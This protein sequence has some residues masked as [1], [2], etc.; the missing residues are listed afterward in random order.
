[1]G[2]PVEE[3]GDLRKK[4]KSRGDN[5]GFND[6]DSTGL[7]R[8]ASE[9]QARKVLSDVDPWTAW[10][11]KPHTIITTLVGAGLLVWASGALQ[12]EEHDLDP[13]TNTKRGVWAVIAVFMGYCLLQAPPTILVRPHPAFWRFIHGMAVVYLVFLTFLLFQ[14]R[15]DARQFLKY[16]HPDLGVQLKERSYGTDCR[17]YTPEKPN[18][19]SN[20]YDTLFDE[21]VVAHTIGWWCKAIMIRNQPFLWALSI[22]FEFCERSLIH[23]LPNFNECWWD[24]FV[25]D[26][27]ICNW[28]GIWAGMKTVKYFDGKEYNWVGVSQQKSFYGKVRRTLG[29]FTPSYWDKDEWNA[30][31]GPW[32]FLEVLALGVVILTVEVMGFFLKFVLWIPPL[33]PLNSYRLAIW[34]LIANPAIREY[35][36]FLQSSE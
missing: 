16:L 33:N 27:L 25:L 9:I 23:M 30:L 15:D 20:V 6:G 24:S 14:N 3:E 28:F 21:Y 26:V 19:F 5:I 31:Q 36:M 8:T 7:V 4:G 13:A 1:M 11:Y 32:R 17:I 29:Q 22:A 35:N 10:L 12:G 18:K 34:W 2:L